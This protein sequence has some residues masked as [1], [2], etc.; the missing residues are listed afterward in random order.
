M[1]IWSC[2]HYFAIWVLELYRQKNTL[3]HQKR[4]YIWER[5]QDKRRKEYFFI[6]LS[7]YLVVASEHSLLPSLI[8]DEQLRTSPFKVTK[9]P[10]E[11]CKVSVCNTTETCPL[12]CMLLSILTNPFTCSVSLLHLT[13]LFGFRQRQHKEERP[14][15]RSINLVINWKDW[16]WGQTYH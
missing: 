3:K 14:E 6:R 5:N 1:R 11:A 13:L 9:M 15:G 12:R 2:A 16:N 10:W 7:F 4:N 8:S